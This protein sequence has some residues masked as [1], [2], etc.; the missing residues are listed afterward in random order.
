[1]K[2]LKV[3]K[4][5]FPYTIP[6]LTG[7]LF[8]GL[9]YGILMKVNGFGLGLTALTSLAIFAGSLQYVG[10]SFLTTA[11][12]PLKVLMMSIIIN[13]RHLFYGI[14]MLEKYNDTGLKKPFLIFGLTDE[15]FSIVC[16]NEPPE[17]V[18]R[19]SF[20]FCITLLNYS[21]WVISGIL[22]NIL[23]NFISFNTTGIDFVLTALFV[24]IFI[25]QWSEEKGRVPAVI[26]VL[27]SVVNLIIFG[28]NNF[29]LPAMASILILLA[30]YRKVFREELK[31]NE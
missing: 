14:S 19:D 30:F 26:G 17:G 15:T 18:D 29:I 27:C 22:G 4:S 31:I 7:Y 6:V 25:N 5:A 11:F 1:M 8:L 23:G 13:A 3:L 2:K 16:S 9:A 12:E 21:Y 24:V 10:I 20:Y 28:P